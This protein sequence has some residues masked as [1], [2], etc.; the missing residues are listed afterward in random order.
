MTDTDIDTRLEPLFA[1]IRA[2]QVNR[3]RATE[4]ARNCRDRY[5]AMID[6]MS[7]PFNELIDEAK[8]EIESIVMG[9]G[10]SYHYGANHA[11]FVSSSVRYSWD[12][13]KLEGYFVAIGEDIEQFRKQTSVEARVDIKL[14]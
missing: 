12:R 7:M 5:Q 2:L 9:D 13:P 14:E 4:E 3:D 6:D 1:K 11:K 8:K 10:C